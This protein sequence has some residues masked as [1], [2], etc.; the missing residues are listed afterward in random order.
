MSIARRI[1]PRRVAPSRSSD[2]ADGATVVAVDGVRAGVGVERVVRSGSTF[3]EA[4]LPLLGV[5]R[6]PTPGTRDVRPF[7]GWSCIDAKALG[8]ALIRCQRQR[9][10]SANRRCFASPTIAPWSGSCRD[11]PR[12]AR[13]VYLRSLQV[14]GLGLGKS[15]QRVLDCRHVVQGFERVRVIVG[16]TRR[17]SYTS[18]ATVPRRR[19]GP[20][21]SRRSAGCSSDPIVSAWL[22][23]ST[24]LPRQGVEPDAIEISEPARR[25]LARSWREACQVIGPN[26]V[27]RWTMST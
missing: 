19:T 8:V 21:G 24:A 9:F 16:Q 25:R 3:N 14:E 4:S 2:P 27:R 18:I 20:D 13:A 6:A 11:A 26:S 23:P 17:R 15:A 7:V 10:G 22:S 12:R 1:V 5:A